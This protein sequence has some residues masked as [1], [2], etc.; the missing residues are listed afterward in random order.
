MHNAY[1]QARIPFQE[2]ANL[3]CTY[4]WTRDYAKMIMAL[5]E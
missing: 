5:I 1:I 2:V 4:I 3:S